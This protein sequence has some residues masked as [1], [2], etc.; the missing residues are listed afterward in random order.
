M[1]E[2]GGVKIT[3]LCPLQ[4]LQLEDAGVHVKLES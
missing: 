2:V 4:L 1:V 3:V